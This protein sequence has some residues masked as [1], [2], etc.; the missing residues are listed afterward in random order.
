MS[1]PNSVK[2]IRLNDLDALRGFAMLLG[3]V[4]HAALAFFP[5]F[6][7][8]QDDYQHEGFAW[9]VSA[10][11][12]FRMPLFF[13]LSGFFTAM[14]WRRRGMGS[15]LKHRFLRV[16]LP[17]MVGVVTIV[18]AVN[19]ISE[20][21]IEDTYGK[22]TEVESTGAAGSWTDPEPINDY[23]EWRLA[24]GADVNE[25]Q[26]ESGM[27]LLSLAAISGRTDTISMLLEKGSDIHNRN[28]DQST[29]LHLAALLGKTEAAEL[30]LEN[31]IDVNARD[32]KGETPLHFA[33][34]LG[35]TET[36]DLLIQ[37]GAGVNI[38]NYEGA[39]PMDSAMVDVETTMWIARMLQ[40]EVDEETL[41]AG[42]ERT[43]ELL[44]Q[45]GSQSGYVVSAEY[46]QED[47]D[48]T[49]ILTP[50]WEMIYSEDLTVDVAE[51]PEG[52]GKYWFPFDGEFNLI[53]STVFHHL[54][55]LWFLVWLMAIFAIVATIVDRLNLKMLPDRFV[56]S[57]LNFL[58]LIPLTMVFQWFMGIG[59]LIPSFGPD[60]ATG[61]LL[62]PHLLL[63]YAVFFG[64][65]ALY[66]SYDDVEGRISKWWW[67]MLPMGMFVNFPLGYEIM[68]A[69]S[70]I[71]RL[72][73]VA[74]QAV[75][76]WLMT[77][78]LM[79]LFRKVLTREIYAVRF[80]SDSS[81]WLYIIHVPLIIG[82]QYVVQE[83]QLPA[84][85]K[86][87]LICIVISAFLLITYR[88]FVR[89]TFVG[90]FLNGPRKRPVKIA[91]VSG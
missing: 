20:I 81:Y 78:G 60:T 82:A 33:A 19:Y 15:L 49:G 43:L 9:L 55:F 39:S 79:G 36:V 53:H 76:P 21:A 83:W 65:G 50:Y 2:A 12:G 6:W 27:T 37:S 68:D 13:L 23:I 86:F 51:K 58:W 77:F 84:M 35:Q 3:I 17:L 54:W 46:D 16:F 72:I 62:P 64:F 5:M 73:S 8:V 1:T 7:P 52:P 57:P 40:I 56:L 32:Y 38:R 47:E 90:T 25:K 14:L 42:K 61:L 80:L 69:N 31:G 66:Y 29:P 75:Y 24:S 22:A 44:G 71:L 91:P 34:F 28:E 4:L 63:Y 70:G 67:L 85:V 74:V 88:Y 48:D 30:L 87:S 26:A 59:G 18:P 89:Y 11:H 45:Q 10:I 41:D